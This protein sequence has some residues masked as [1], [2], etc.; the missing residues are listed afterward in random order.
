MR[1][2]LLPGV[3]ALLALA[4]A[5]GAGAELVEVEAVGSVPLAAGVSGG[6]NARQAALNT[7][8]H[9]VIF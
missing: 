1:S 7:A 3:V 4:L 2:R 9:L 5:G 6:A 8:V